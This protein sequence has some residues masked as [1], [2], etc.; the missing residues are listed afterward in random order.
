ML[1]IT[2]LH[3]FLIGIGVICLL[4][5]A[6]KLYCDIKGI[7]L[8]AILSKPLM[9]STPVK[10]PPVPPVRTAPAPTTQS[11]VDPKEAAQTIAVVGEAYR[12]LLSQFGDIAAISEPLRAAK[13]FQSDGNTAEAM[14]AGLA[15]WK[16]LKQYRAKAA[17]EP[18]TYE[19]TR[20]DT[21]WKI[22][23]ARSPVKAGAG[24]VAIWKANKNFVNNFDRL[25]VGWLLKIPPKRAQYVTPFW[26]PSSIHH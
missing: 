15:A 6:A 2:R 3:L 4:A 9:K 17:Q 5:G 22:A 13:K 8:P 10:P 16:A 20:G 18:D 23:A 1:R 24:W 26:S 11:P 12:P 14:A 7:P 25:E 21:L 19:V